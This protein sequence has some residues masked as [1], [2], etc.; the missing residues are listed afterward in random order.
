MKKKQAK[1]KPQYNEDGRWVEERGRIKG[2]L[3]TAFR[4]AP[5]LQDVLKAARV[6]LP[7]LPKKDGS[8]GKRPRVRYR[9]AICG[10]LFPL[11]KGGKTYVQVDHIDPVVPLHKTESKMPLDE[12]ILTMARGIFC[13]TDNLQA[14][15]AMS[16][17]NN[18][19]KP[20][21]HKKKTDEENWIRRQLS[22][23][24]KDY[25]QYDPL[26]L[27]NLI[28]IFRIEYKKELK[29]KEERNARRKRKSQKWPSDPPADKKD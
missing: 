19:G 22:A 27:S 20:S 12:W 10:E 29:K 26:D 9:C 23:Q 1:N 7:P 11:T 18:D 13:S 4:Q 24:D 28:A 3:R 25:D 16:M 5:Q 14:V 21:C 15:C 6:E 17:K 2:A 8:P